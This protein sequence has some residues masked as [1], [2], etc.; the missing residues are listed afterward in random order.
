MMAVSALS[1][2][3]HAKTTN[4]DWLQNSKTSALLVKVLIRFNGYPSSNC[5]IYLN[6]GGFGEVLKARNKLDKC[7]YAIKRIRTNPNN[8]QYNRQIMR[9]IKLLSRLNHENV[10]RYYSTWLERYVPDPETTPAT[11]TPAAAATVAVATAAVAAEFTNNKR[12]SQSQATI[13]SKTLTLVLFLIIII[14][15]CV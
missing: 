13:H 10:V 2:T 6:A 8:K 7:F 14:I 12:K 9:E 3:I 5:I 15:K 11:Q 1:T 4:Q